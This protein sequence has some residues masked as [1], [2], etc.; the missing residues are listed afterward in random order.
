MFSLEW[1]TL[2]YLP[3]SKAIAITLL[4]LARYLYIIFV[5]LI[6]Q[7]LSRTVKLSMFFLLCTNPVGAGNLRARYCTLLI[8]SSDQQHACL[9][10]HDPIINLHFIGI[11]LGLNQIRDLLFCHISGGKVLVEDWDGSI[12]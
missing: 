7:Y 1:L 12:Q 6:I 2:P 4:E 10:L 5:R 3:Y 11:H 8:C 9:I